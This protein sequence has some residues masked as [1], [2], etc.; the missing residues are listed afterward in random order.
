MGASRRCSARPP[1]GEHTSVSL[2]LQILAVYV[3]TS[4]TVGLLFGIAS[5]KLIL[6]GDRRR[7]HEIALLARPRALQAV[8][9]RRASVS[10]AGQ[11]PGR[12]VPRTVP[13]G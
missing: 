6:R 10:R 4:L 7:Q 11:V 3:A 2:L 1:V 5:G 8:G 12:Q 9:S 13:H